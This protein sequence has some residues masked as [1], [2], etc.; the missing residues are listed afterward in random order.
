MWFL[1]FFFYTYR[2]FKHKGVVSNLHACSNGLWKIRLSKI[3]HFSTRIL[4]STQTKVFNIF[5]HIICR[6]VQQTNVQLS[7]MSKWLAKHLSTKVCFKTSTRKTHVYIDIDWPWILY[8]CFNFGIWTGDRTK[9]LVLS[10]FQLS[11][12][13]NSQNTNENEFI[14]EHW[15]IN[16]YINI[17]I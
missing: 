4:T 13:L 14:N 9:M 3:F 8:Q 10:S 15:H 1:K 5:S 12:Q 7:I 6:D 17:G 16:L 11:T 2:V